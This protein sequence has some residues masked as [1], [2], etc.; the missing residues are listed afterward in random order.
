MYIWLALLLP[1]GLLIKQMY[2][3]KIKYSTLTDK[4]RETFGMRQQWRCYICG[5]IML[6]DFKTC[7]I[8]QNVRAICINCSQQHVENL[9]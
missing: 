2:Y 9:V 4:E 5:Q 8:Q 1:F 3:C 7:I 6:S